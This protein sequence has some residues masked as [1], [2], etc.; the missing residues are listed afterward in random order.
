MDWDRGQ[1][2]F[3]D[4]L[5]RA[6]LGKRHARRLHLINLLS[7]SCLLEEQRWVELIG[8]IIAGA[9]NFLIRSVLL[10]SARWFP[11]GFATRGCLLASCDLPRAGSRRTQTV[12]PWADEASTGSTLRFRVC[13]RMLEIDGIV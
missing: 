7:S 9:R 11:A 6:V 8:P 10:L 5:R 4:G 1:V 3:I 13:K 12:L 2:Q